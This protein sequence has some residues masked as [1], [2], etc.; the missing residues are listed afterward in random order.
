MSGIYS[1][2]HFCERSTLTMFD[3]YLL[4]YQVNPACLQL[5]LELVD[6]CFPAQQASQRQILHHL[7]ADLLINH[8][9]NRARSPVVALLVSHPVNQV[10]NHS[11]DPRGYLLSNPLFNRW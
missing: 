2:D 6:D 5:N 8:Q 1:S 3:H 7:A 9:D 10:G 11:R 4:N